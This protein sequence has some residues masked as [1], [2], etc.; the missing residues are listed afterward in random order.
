M[1]EFD[2]HSLVRTDKFNVKLSLQMQ[3]QSKLFYAKS[4][5]Y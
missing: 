3:R 4:I 2:G 5:T 1:D